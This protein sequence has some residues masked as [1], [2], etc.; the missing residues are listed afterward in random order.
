MFK[1][2]TCKSI[3]SRLAYFEP[4][5]DLLLELWQ[6]TYNLLVQVNVQFPFTIT[7]NNH[8]DV[9]SPI[10]LKPLPL[11]EGSSPRNASDATARAR[12]LRVERIQ[13]PVGPGFFFLR[14]IDRT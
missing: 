9:N 10:S 8:L 7:G 4:V 14:L 1:K 2:Y 11:A 13:L 6:D 5:E 3:P 12:R